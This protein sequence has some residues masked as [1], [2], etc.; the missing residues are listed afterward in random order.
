MKEAFR[1]ALLWYRTNIWLRI[2]RKFRTMI[3]VLLGAA[4]AAA[5]QQYIA[6]NTDFD[7]MW[8][9][10]M[11]AAGTVLARM[12]NPADDYAGIV[13]APHP[14]EEPADLD[15]AD[16]DTPNDAPPADEVVTDDID[17]S[18]EQDGEPGAPTSGTGTDV[19]TPDNADFIDPT[20]GGE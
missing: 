2:P 8:D 11:I 5:V 13:V 19:S 1:N 12:L 7:S 16:S 9:A 17:T 6:G 3:N 20:E 18:A 14:D 15:P 4:L 10:I